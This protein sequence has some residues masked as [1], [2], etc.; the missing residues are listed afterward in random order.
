[1]SSLT[2][3]STPP[4]TPSIRSPIPSTPNTARPPSKL[5]ATPPLT[6]NSSAPVSPTPQHA[7]YLTTSDLASPLSPLPPGETPPVSPGVS[8]SGRGG[9]ARDLLR[10]HYGLG[11]VAATGNLRSK[12]PMDLDSSNFDAKAYYEH[13]ITTAT[14]PELLKK[15]NEL[16]QEIKQLDGER[17]SLVYNHH[18]ELIAASDTIHAMKTRAESLDADLD[19]LMTAFSEISRLSAE[20]SVEPHEN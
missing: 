9:R 10:K 15:E 3:L 1:M 20:V 6:A 13:L 14:L 12:D 18:H 17:Q 7:Q 5:G 4:S 8:R 2:P 11:V 16:V 19:K